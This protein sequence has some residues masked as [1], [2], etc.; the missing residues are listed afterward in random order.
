MSLL[1]DTPTAT[2]ADTA[3]DDA[4]YLALKARDARFDGR[5]FVGVTS[6]GI[7]CRPVCK[8]RAPKRE[9]CRFFDLPAQAEH[10]GFRPCMRCRPELAPATAPAAL[11]TH[12]STQ[13]ASSILA[14]QAAR[15]LDSSEPWNAGT[16]S[17]V[18]LAQRLGISER[19]LR[20][21]FETQW[22]V[23]PL[24]YLQTRRLLTAKRLLTD[25]ALRVATVA[26]LSGYASVRRFNAVF[27]AH[28]RLQPL[29]LRKTIAPKTLG[30]QSQGLVLR[31]SYRQPFDTDAMLAF[32]ATRCVR[33][34]EWVDPAQRRIART[35]RIA[36]KGY[37]YTGWV[38]AHFLSA[39]NAVEFHISES[40]T[41]VLPLVLARLHAWLDLDTDPA[42][43]A[44]Q[45]GPQ[46]AGLEGRRVPGTL[47]G[48]ELA[49]RA[50]LGQ[51]ITVAAARTLADRLVAHCGTPLP[52]P[53]AALTHTFPSAER[54][55]TMPA[56]ELGALGIVRQRQKAI[57][58]LAQA[59][60]DGR[61]ALHA[62]VDIAPTM[63]ALQALPGIG[64]WTANYIAMRALR[65]PD[66]FVAGDVA[67]QKALGVRDAKH[68]AQAAEQASQAWKP[69]RSYAV[70]RAWSLLN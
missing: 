21:I 66:A 38:Q 10:A 46:F 32:F 12:W 53:F 35:V 49:V 16:P 37:V 63:A 17:V 58:T 19:H 52:T 69:W 33:G 6:T 50:I 1:R 42:P 7:Y 64:A 13:D 3:K 23:S 70:V 14:L 59:V 22:G 5:F 34:I 54:L 60:V 30:L 41:P 44:Q 27:L 20:R 28:Y 18:Q 56:S 8:V 51:Q 65:W 61:I 57:G 40:L 25:T 24:Q 67:L 62:S 29:A 4:H 31:A 2:K 36:H 11:G 45:L 26:H 48:F 68:P 15:L 39:A 9:N 47:D 55:A 43:I